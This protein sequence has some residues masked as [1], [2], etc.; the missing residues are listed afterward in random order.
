MKNKQMGESI[1]IDSVSTY[2]KLRGAET[3]HPMISVLD[4]E[5]LK[6]IENVTYKFELYAVFFKET[7][8][9]DIK[10][11]KQIYDYQE[12]SLV[13]VAPNQN[14]T[15]GSYKNNLKPK[16]KVLL[17]HPDFIRGTALGKKIYDYT[18]FHY[19]TN[20]A[21]HLSERESNVIVDLFN[22]IN[23]ELH[24]NIDKYSKTII[25][26]TLQLILNYSERFYDRQFITRTNV[27][28]DIVQKF[29][30][31]LN[32]YLISKKTQYF[33]LPSVTFCANE[34]NLSANYFGDLIKKELGTTAQEYIQSKIIEVAKTKIFDSEKSISQ[35]AYELGFK[36][37]QH[38]NR[39]FKQ[40]V[41]IT[42]NEYRNLN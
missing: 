2:N 42:P 41:G 28:T 39:L 14:L 15:V 6:M 5:N 18:F 20:E 12:E 3:L 13:F 33:G 11:G 27:S 29:E 38:F 9:G 26:D 19:E 31:I 4:Y 22:K 16:G 30:Q 23:F 24:Q 34:L 35:V 25:V 36:Y 40:K 7:I 21:L 10:Y 8:C 17:F 32:A 37:P 1:I